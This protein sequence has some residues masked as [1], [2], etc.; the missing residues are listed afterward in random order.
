MTLNGMRLKWG[1]RRRMSDALR[2]KLGGP[3]QN[4]MLPLYLE[5]LAGGKLSCEALYGESRVVNFGLRCLEDMT[6]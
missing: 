5:R 1:D 6:D 3:S 2:Q 4:S